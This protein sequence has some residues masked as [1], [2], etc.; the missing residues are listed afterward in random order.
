MP[1]YAFRCQDCGPYDE[2]YPIGTAP[3]RSSC[4]GCGGPSVRLITAPG[5]T[6]GRNPYRGAVERTV[7]SAETPQVVS[8]LPGRGRRSIPIST[9]PLHRKLPRP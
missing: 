7:A 9:N 2:R 6:G 4:P 3:D 5:L 1:T 8:A